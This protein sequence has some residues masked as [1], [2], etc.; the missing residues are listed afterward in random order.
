VAVA[1]SIPKSSIF[2]KANLLELTARGFRYKGSGFT[3]ITRGAI[4]A[5]IQVE[6]GVRNQIVR[7]EL[8]VA[9]ATV[10]AV[11][12]AR[13]YASRCLTVSEFWSWTYDDGKSFSDNADEIAP[14]VA[15]LWGGDINLIKKSGPPKL[16]DRPA[17]LQNHVA[18]ALHE[19][20]PEELG[21]LVTRRIHDLD[22]QTLLDLKAAITVEIVRRDARQSSLTRS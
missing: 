1:T 9:L 6:A 17:A 11:S 21:M 18:V 22:Y 8:T 15:A 10:M 14:A 4:Y 7:E 20:T 12:S 13:N 19:V 2:D 5:L 3:A 16:A